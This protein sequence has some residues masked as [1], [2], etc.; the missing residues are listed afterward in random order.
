MDFLHILLT[1]FIF[2]RNLNLI[3]KLVPSLVLFIN[4]VIISSG[5]MLE[6]GKIEL[7]KFSLRL[8]LLSEILPLLNLFSTEGP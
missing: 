4:M 8:P 7:F 6:M 5:L 1:P 3:I 2:L